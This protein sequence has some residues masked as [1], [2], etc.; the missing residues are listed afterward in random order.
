MP[1]PGPI[2]KEILSALENNLLPALR[3]QEVPIG[4]ITPALRFPAGITTRLLTHVV[5]RHETKNVDY[6]L[7]TRWPRANLHSSHLPYFGLIYK[8][9]LDARTLITGKQAIA[10][11]SVKGIHAI[12]LHAPAM[13]IY[14]PHA[15]RDGGDI[16]FWQDPTVK[17][18]E[19]GSLWG[20]FH[21][22][23]R[24]VLIHT[25]IR[26]ARGERHISHSLQLCDP[27]IAAL[28]TLL[29]Q[30]MPKS[31]EGKQEYSRAVLL[32]LMEG[33]YKILGSSP[34]KIANTSRSP[35]PHSKTNVTE[36]HSQ[37]TCRN[38]AIYIQ[39]HLHEPITL[40]QIAQHAGLSSAHL[41]RLF[42]Q[43]YGVT[44][45]R[46]VRQQRIAAARK[47]LEFGPE[48]VAEIASLVGFN[49]ASAFCDVFRRETGLTPSGYRKKVR[50]NQ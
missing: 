10:R 33:I 30:E 15:A 7:H 28:C 23:L 1:T 4:Y 39:M 19:M 20:S 21:P 25:H 40:S 13:L 17:P 35:I 22:E 5:P 44:L 8:G 14:P 18:S 32:A 34:G 47:M 37:E 9:A 50:R 36:T 27:S 26:N 29:L 48:N 3:R 43:H 12:R 38:S 45:M 16:D 2:R 41:N 46:Y 42:Q 11:Q 31:L 24:E 6:P 49:R